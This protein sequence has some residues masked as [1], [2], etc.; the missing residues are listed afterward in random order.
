MERIFC[1]DKLD[2]DPNS[3]AAEK[4]YKHWAFDQ[5]RALDLAQRTSEAFQPLSPVIAAA[6]G[7]VEE[8][9][10]SPHTNQ[11]DI[12]PVE[13]STLA[14]MTTKKRCWF[15]GGSL[16]LRARCPAKDSD[17]S[18]CGKRGHWAKV[19]QTEGKKQVTASISSPTLCAI[20]AAVPHCLNCSA[21]NLKVNG[22][23]ISGLIDLASSESFID[24]RV[25][26]RLKL[27]IK[28]V[29]QSITLAM[30]SSTASVIS[31]WT[32]DLYVN[33]S[34]YS[35]TRLGVIE[36]LCGD[37]ILC[38]DFQKQH[39]SVT[40][41]YGGPRPELKISN[42]GNKPVC[43]LASA[44]MSEP[45]LFANMQRD[46][47]PIA[48]KSRKFS[49][50]DQK[51]ITKEIQR[52]LFEGIIESSTSPWR[53]QV[54]IAR[55]DSGCH[56]KRMSIDDSSTV[57]I[58]TNLNAYPLPNI[59]TMVNTLAKYHVFSTFVLKSAY[60]QLRISESDKPF[61]AFEA[62]GRLY[63]FTRV[64][65]GVT[66]GVAVFQRAIDKFVEEENLCDT[67]PY[68][69]N[70]TIDGRD[71]KEHDANL[72]KF[73]AAAEERKLTLNTSKSTTSATS[74]NLLGYQLGNGQIKPD[75]E[76]LKPLQELPPPTS[77]STLQRVLVFP[78]VS[79]PIT[80]FFR[81]HLEPS[82]A[83]LNQTGR[84]VAFMSRMLSGSEIHYPPVEEPTAI[85]EAVR[86]WS[87]PLL[88][89]HFTIVTDQ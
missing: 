17:C 30:S 67:F 70:S 8:T 14:S 35:N 15:C 7:C 46:A 32:V 68:L 3:T 2:V 23:R 43:S 74:I 88:G 89:R 55:D 60:H 69:D 58:Y 47:K 1:P 79:L 39:S 34:H 57:N 19:C 20:S 26:H 63:Q 44:G 21:T 16:H 53:A 31:E 85:I 87:H 54:V 29:S 37:V 36:N 12:H 83:T 9:V 48:T 51:L 65:F 66:Y 10:K 82:S 62:H 33:D 84:P 24:K 61:T 11:Q 6:S 73:L 52:L 78:G 80:A 56:R 22:R 40:K 75:P 42:I 72:E 25:A 77:R 41:E 45:L 50:D 13:D 27:H 18:S 81:E 64:P 59:E 4:E 49:P 76:R 5:A 38:I 28:P 86:K 71:Q